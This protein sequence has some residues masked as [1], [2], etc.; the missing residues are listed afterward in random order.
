M[1][2]DKNR[3]AGAN[4]QVAGSEDFSSLV[5][6]VSRMLSEWEDSDELEAEFAERLIS[7]IGGH[8]DASSL[9][10]ARKASD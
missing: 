8:K 5:G 1:T 6:E 4:Y 10:T 3:Q 7:H 2:L 9:P